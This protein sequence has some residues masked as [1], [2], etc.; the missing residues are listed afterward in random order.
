MADS[1][2]Y[3]YFESRGVRI[4]NDLSEFD[5]TRGAF[6]YGRSTHDAKLGDWSDM[7]LVL[8]IHQ[9]VIPSSTWL[10]C[11]QK[12]NKNKVSQYL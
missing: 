12:L 5:G 9:G 2:V 3:D 10:K 4:V 7:K 1:A 6:L 11:Q 8:G